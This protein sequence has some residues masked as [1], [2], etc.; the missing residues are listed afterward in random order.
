MY[1]A[2]QLL[3]LL[4]NMEDV[5][6]MDA[7]M[8]VTTH[9]QTLGLMAELQELVLWLLACATRVAGPNNGTR[10]QNLAMPPPIPVSM[11]VALRQHRSSKVS[12]T[13]G[14]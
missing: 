12:K 10:I 9:V 6:P 2:P 7:F 11:T 14:V 13:F 1:V 5:R 8:R 4:I 3:P